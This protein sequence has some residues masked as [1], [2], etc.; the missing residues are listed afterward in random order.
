MVVVTP[1]P[2]PEPTP[3][4]G[5]DAAEAAAEEA[6]EAADEAV[7]AAEAAEEAADE[8]AEEAADASADVA[9]LRG[10]IGELRT[11]VETGFA[12]IRAVM[13]PPAVS[14]ETEIA[15]EPPPVAIEPVKPHWSTRMPKWLI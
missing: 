5:E 14:A 4:P 10:E 1:D 2:S 3:T 6:E 8:A 7:E 15:V 11:T 13:A 12:E 9:Q